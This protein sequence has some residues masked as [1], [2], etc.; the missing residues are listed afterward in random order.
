MAPKPLTMNPNYV[1]MLRGTRELHRL[2]AAGKDDSPEADAIRDA[3]DGPWEALSEAERK[4]V[5]SK[6]RALRASP[7]AA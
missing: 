3:T 4:R 7:R 2:L 1:A 5:R 6:P